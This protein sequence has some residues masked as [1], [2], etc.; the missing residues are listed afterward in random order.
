M[1]SGFVVDG[2]FFAGPDITQGDEEDMAVQNL[3]VR[4]RLARVVDVMGAVT[5]TAPIQ[6]P[7]LID[8]ADTQSAPSSPASRLRIGYFFSC[9]LRDLPVT[10]EV[11]D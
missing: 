6:T 9:I 3:H 8:A 7:P 2:D 5:T 10:L 4:V 1:E 11:G